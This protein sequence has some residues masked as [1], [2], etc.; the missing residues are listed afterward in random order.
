MYKY[1]DSINLLIYI[2]GNKE[3]V[4]LED[5]QKAFS[6]CIINL[7]FNKKTTMKNSIKIMAVALMLGIAVQANAQETADATASATV[8]APIAITKAADMLFGNISDA[9]SGGTVVLATDNGRTSTGTV[10]LPTGGTVNA[11]SFTVTGEADYAY[12]FSVPAG[13]YDIETGVA[14]AGEVMSIGTWTENSTGTLTGGSETVSLGA[15][16]TVVAGQVA[17]AYANATPFTVSV[18]Y[19]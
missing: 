15:T 1:L 10:Q 16:L 18:I 9:G 13:T 12:T 7:K 3:L 17:G 2:C 6:F 11:A 4:I 19:N 14:G 5:V 8:V